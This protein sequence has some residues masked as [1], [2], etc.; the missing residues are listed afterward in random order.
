MKVSATEKLTAPVSLLWC[1]AP[2]GPLDFFR[3][4]VR[5][6]P[7]SSEVRQSIRNRNF[8][9]LSNCLVVRWFGR[10]DSVA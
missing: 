9:G 10:C 6:K 7:T 2:R 8:D 4:Q 5:S 1:Q 3:K